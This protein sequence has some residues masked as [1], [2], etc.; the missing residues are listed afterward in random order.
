[1]MKMKSHKPALAMVA[2][3]VLAGAVLTISPFS[4]RLSPP[5]MEPD[6]VEVMAYA[7]PEK[8]SIAVL[9]FVNTAGDFEQEYF[10]D[11]MTNELITD[12]S[13][14]S[15]LFV[16]ARHSVFHY[17][18]E[19]VGVK[20]VS[21]ELDVRY[22]L[23]GS[24]RRA[25][26][27]VRINT[28]LTDATT[29]ERLWA[30]RYDSKMDD[31]FTMQD[32]ITQKIVTTLKVKLTATE[33]EQI[34]RKETGNI[35]AYD[36]FMKGWGHYFR[37]T[38]TDIAMA[39]FYFDQAVELD[40]DYGRA[41][42]G[43]AQ[44]YLAS[45]FRL[46][47][48]LGISYIEAMVRTR[49]YLRIAMRN[50]IPSAY[51]IKAFMN[52]HRRQHKEAVATAELA[53]ALN[54]NDPMMHIGMAHV[55][56][57]AG[58][59]KEAVDF[60]R[61]AMRHDPFNIHHPLRHLGMAH[62]SLGQYEKAAAFLERALKHKP[63][64]LEPYSYLAASYAHIGREQKAR[65]ALNHFIGNIGM[66]SPDLRQIMS[67]TPFKDPE[68]ADRFAVGLIKAGLPGEPTEY[69]RIYEANKLTGE[70]VRKLTFGRTVTGFV[71]GKRQSWFDI[72]K[73]GRAKYRGPMGFD[74]GN[75][76]IDGDLFCCQMQ[77]MTKGLKFCGLFFRNPEGTIDRKNEY[78]WVTDLGILPKS[79]VDWM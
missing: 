54:P 41:F 26:N 17:K 52:L 18:G 40:P 7:L 64:F 35:E 76:L 37:Q 38:P 32:K 5:L 28:Q 16:I 70:E 53:I 24:V 29:G 73:D 77:G 78:L 20:V 4:L 72:A 33:Q 9:P 50:Q 57:F 8:P 46:R 39:V 71:Q 31:I 67:Y 13:K 48:S 43:L 23:E 14:I 61:K 22:L 47:R 62:F 34:Y 3:L 11:G 21:R 66:R 42:A 30:A 6:F 65:V 79:V 2:V 44:I 56:I 10:A 12:L 59:P 27:K 1:M 51:R 15:G 69:Y 63:E 60:A 36:A 55:L 19:P 75:F 25:D 58:R 68:I 49:E 45:D 74:K